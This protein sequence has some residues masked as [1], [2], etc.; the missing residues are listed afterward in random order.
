MAFIVLYVD[1]ILLMG[2]D[3]LTLKAVKTWLGSNFSMKDLGDASYILGMRIYRER[4]SRM[5]GLSQSTYIDKVLHRFGMQNAK[6]GYVPVSQGIT[7]SKD[8]CPKSLDEKDRMNKVSYASAIGSI[9][10]VM[11]CTRPD[12]S[13]T[14]SMTS[15]YQS[16]PGEGHWTAVKNIFKYLKRIKIHSWCMEERRNS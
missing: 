15:R 13:Y 10:Y 7:I 14:L 12:V 8:Q 4:S 6:R 9:M 16:N 1:D 3:I 11:V 2:N 5:I